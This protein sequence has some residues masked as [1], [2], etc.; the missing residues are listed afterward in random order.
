MVKFIWETCLLY[1]SCKIHSIL[2][3]IKTLESSDAANSLAALNSPANFPNLLKLRTLMCSKERK[4][5]SLS[6]VRLFATP[7]TVAYQA[8]PSMGLSRQEYWSWVPLPGTI[9][10]ISTLNLVWGLNGSYLEMGD[11]S[12]HC[13]SYTFS[14]ITLQI[15]CL[16]WFQ[17][18]EPTSLH[19]CLRDVE[20]IQLTQIGWG[21]AWNIC[22]SRQSS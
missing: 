7:W 11:Y 14:G 16:L 20:F 15:P 4:V 2:Y 8:P 5:K 21:L 12:R 17:H 18:P 10:R 9:W 19:E 1:S 13:T 22:L 6:R 3:H